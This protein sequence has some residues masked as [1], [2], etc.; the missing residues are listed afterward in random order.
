M[1]AV[2][3]RARRARPRPPF[4]RPPFPPN[5]VSE[6]VRRAT[7]PPRAAKGPASRQSHA[8]SCVRVVRVGADTAPG[9]AGWRHLAEWGGAH[10]PHWNTKPI[11]RARIRV[12]ASSFNVAMSR[13]WIDSDRVAPPSRSGE[14]S[15]HA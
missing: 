12:L 3:R 10:G 7:N 5:V 13:P 4:P 11:S 14:R 6:S 9:V 15:R 8:R 2:A 1:L